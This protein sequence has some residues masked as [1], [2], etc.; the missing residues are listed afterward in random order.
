[1]RYATDMKGPRM[2]SVF[3]VLQDSKIVGRIIANHSDNPAGSVC[4]ATVWAPCMETGEGS[5]SRCCATGTAGGY[6]YDKLSA[7]IYEALGRS[8]MERA[9]KTAGHMFSGGDGRHVQVFEA[10]GYELRQ[11]L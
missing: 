3:V 9:E 1:M 2:T 7:A 11:L 8:N 10:L 5:Q 6:G 4:T